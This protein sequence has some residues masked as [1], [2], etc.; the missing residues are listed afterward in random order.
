MASPP[1]VAGK[2]SRQEKPRRYL[3]LRDRLAEDKD[4]KL[5]P[6]WDDEVLNIGRHP[7]SSPRIGD[8]YNT[9]VSRRHCEIYVV[10]YDEFDSNV[11][12]RD[13]NTRNGTFVNNVRIGT[14]PGISPSHLLQDGD[15][16]DIHPNW[17]MTYYDRQ[18][19]QSNARTSIQE[20]EHG[21]FEKK[22]RVS[23]RCLGQGAEGMVYLA[24]EVETKKQL[25]CKV[26]DLSKLKGR[27]APEDI[28]RKLQ[29]ADVLRQLQHP[30]IV[31]YVDA[32]VSP[33][34]LYT[35]TELATGG[36]LWS[37]L[38]QRPL[39]GE[40]D[41][42]VIVRQLVQALD[43][44]HKKGVVHRDLKPENILLAYSPNVVCPRILLSD[45]G[46]C[47]V[48]RRSR[49]LTHA[50]TANYQA[51]EILDQSE[52]H[53]A[54]VDMWSLGIVTLTLLT[55]GMDISLRG[56][57]RMTQEE[58]HAFVEEEAL[59]PGHYSALC[60]EFIMHCLQTLPSLRIS[61]MQARNHRWLC[62]PERHLRHFEKL[63]RISRSNWK[64]CEKLRPMPLQL[65][66]VTDEHV[67]WE[68]HMRLSNLIGAWPRGNSEAEKTDQS[69][70]YFGMPVQP[71]DDDSSS[72][73]AAVTEDK[74]S[75]DL[76]RSVAQ[77]S[78]IKPLPLKSHDEDSAMG[79]KK[80]ADQPA[81]RRMSSLPLPKHDR[82]MGEEK[83]QRK[84]I[85]EEL[86]RAKVKFLPDIPAFATCQAA[87]ET[88][89]REQPFS[90]VSSP[91]RGRKRQRPA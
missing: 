40:F 29:E 34:S 91:V 74:F 19:P 47:A 71:E 64:A 62:W 36:D 31:R 79:T 21:L 32:I 45:F 80:K 12:V 59:R 17:T 18:I 14:G 41:T 63:E 57:D 69:S 5:V 75:W 88:G 13:R 6:I 81:G 87:A 49:M 2:K 55:H 76:S 50:G 83:D 53:T 33:H 3:I 56:L 10:V 58:L 30:N 4:Q 70:E 73:V 90:D 15:V 24:T 1:P 16:I 77:T 37:F 52:P 11:Y 72:K 9:V 84:L 82:P 86:R 39:V 51:P 61:S 85:I 46:A 22:Y 7:E 26:V 44:I 42:R 60:E 54:C 25:V 48:P 23:Q 43:Y 66:D 38:Y 89:A 68:E 8:G 65:P 27:N 20:M 28:R 35:F 78:P 67:S